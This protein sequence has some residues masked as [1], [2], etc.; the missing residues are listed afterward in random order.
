MALY[1]PNCLKASSYIANPLEKQTHGFQSQDANIG[2][3][4]YSDH[5][6]NGSFVIECGVLWC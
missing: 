4:F 6:I 2:R 1:T 5:R 3:F